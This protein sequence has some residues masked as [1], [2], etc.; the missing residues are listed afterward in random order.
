MITLWEHVRQGDSTAVR[1][2]LREADLIWRSGENLERAVLWMERAA[3]FSQEEGDRD[4]A[5]ELAA[6]ALELSR[7]VQ[8]RSG[9]PERS[10]PAWMEARRIQSSLIEV[11]DSWL[12][13]VEREPE[14]TARPQMETLPELDVI[15]EA[16]AGPWEEPPTLPRTVLPPGKADKI[17]P[18][19]GSFTE[20]V[21]LLDLAGSAGPEVV[22][23]QPSRGEAEASWGD[24]R[25]VV[26]RCPEFE[27]T[28]DRKLDALLN[29]GSVLRLGD[30]A[31]L[32]GWDAGVVL[33][34]KVGLFQRGLISHRIHEGSSFS[35]SGS[36]PGALVHMAALQPNTWVVAWD[37]STLE[38][39][40]DT[41]PWVL[42]SL[43]NRAD[44][45]LTLAAIPLGSVARYLGQAF[46]QSL[47]EASRVVVLSPGTLLF[48]PPTEVHALHIVGVGE[49][50]L[51]DGEGEVERAAR[52]QVL[53]ARELV[54]GAAAP[55]TARVGKNGAT[56][57]HT[58]AVA[59]PRFLP[60]VPLLV[61][62]LSEVG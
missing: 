9:M 43:R 10:D 21:L 31:A 1:R 24:V 6:H 19:L 57:L 12:D 41:C 52:G 49:V 7:E 54:R 25:G 22:V 58:E 27:D 48:E 45:L 61:R 3:A 62:A 53:F 47:V 55:R 50:E 13:P 56:V 38:S 26:D 33:E 18:V 17:R 20:Q 30:R 16:W 36:V 39:V 51:V 34:G 4:R 11:R 5:L 59:L 60:H 46:V 28:P 14:G 37:R 32:A 2:A 29:T 44:E 42:E 8:R 15:D 23:Q 35:C 40:L